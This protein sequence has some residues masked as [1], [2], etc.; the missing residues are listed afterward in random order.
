MPSGHTHDRITL[1]S[2]PI[3]AAISLW[4][5]RSSTLTLALVGGF[6]FGGLMLGPD[7]DTRSIHHRRWGWFRWIWIPYRNSISHRSPLSHGP[8]IGST[9]R[10]I[11]LTIVVGFATVFALAALNEVLGLGWTWGALGQLISTRASQYRQVAI[12]AAVGL[13]A[14]ALGH[15]VSD[16]ALSS[17]K[18]VRKRY[19]NEGWRSLLIPFKPSKPRKAKSPRSRRSKTSRKMPPRPR[20]TA[21]SKGIPAVKS[22]LRPR[23]HKNKRQ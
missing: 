5:T 3:V 9:I 6:L 17:A 11:Y 1:W 7:L 13:E 12:A 10:V 19:P 16:W 22:L 21:S 2:L 15:Y 8:V 14:G 18:Q 4:A 20:Q 23:R